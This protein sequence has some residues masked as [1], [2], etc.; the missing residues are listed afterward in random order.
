M[1]KTLFL[2]LGLLFVAH[3]TSEISFKEG[4]QI[5]QLINTE[6]RLTI[7]CEGGSGI[8]LITCS[9]LPE[10]WRQIGNSLVVPKILTAKGDY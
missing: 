9:N 8:Y 3:S 6:G 5:A 4:P 10:G 1:Y 2:I 7:P